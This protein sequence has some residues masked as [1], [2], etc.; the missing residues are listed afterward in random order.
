MWGRAATER[1]S[2]QLPRAHCRVV[3]ILGELPSLNTL[4]VDMVNLGVQ[5]GCERDACMKYLLL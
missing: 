1:F 2:A 4:T 3:W 5:S